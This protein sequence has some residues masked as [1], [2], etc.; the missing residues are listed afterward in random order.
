MHMLY[1]CAIDR[2]GARSCQQQA[3]RVLAPQR[4]LDGSS[5]AD[6]VLSIELNLGGG[7]PGDRGSDVSSLADAAMQV[8][9]VTFLTV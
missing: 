8:G 4:G 6:Q 9:H 5:I 7:H 1:V 2:Y 3:V